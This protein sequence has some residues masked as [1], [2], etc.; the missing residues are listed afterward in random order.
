MSLRL[1]SLRAEGPGAASWGLST[2]LCP[3][4][5]A[6]PGVAAARQCQLVCPA[7]SSAARDTLYFH[8]RELPPRV[9]RASCR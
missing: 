7:L 4:L 6:I 9:R 1:L 3:V 2:P 5:F 8:R